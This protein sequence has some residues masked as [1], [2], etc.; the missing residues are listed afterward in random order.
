MLCF[1]ETEAITLSKAKLLEWDRDAQ[2]D[3]QIQWRRCMEQTNTSSA[4]TGYGR[5]GGKSRGGYGGGDVTY[6]PKTM[7]SATRVKTE[8]AP[9]P[10]SFSM[11]INFNKIDKKKW[12]HEYGE[13]RINGKVLIMCWYQC[14]R[15]GGC[16]RKDECAHDH[17]HFPTEYKGRHLEKCSSAFQKEVLKKCSGA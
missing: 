3:Q 6:Q 10:K 4:E 12:Q 11:E 7:G 1:K 2:V 9:A 5:F 17:K 15:P 14:N 13:T 8:G 16:V